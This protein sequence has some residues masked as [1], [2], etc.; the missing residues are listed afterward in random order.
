MLR[1]VGSDDMLKRADIRPMLRLA[2]VPEMVTFAQ[3]VEEAVNEQL[4]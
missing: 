2:P 4:S 1:N 3:S